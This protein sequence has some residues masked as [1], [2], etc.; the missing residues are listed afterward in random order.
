MKVPLSFKPHS[1]GQKV[2]KLEKVLY[3]LKQSP[4][5]W[6]GRFAKVT[7]AM[8]YK[9]SQRDDMVVKHLALRG[10]MILFE[11]VDDAVVI[12]DYL[13]GRET[14]TKCLVK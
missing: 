3:G 8:G 7:I 13:E 10:V 4:R 12:R 11:Y 6:F 5:A 9:Q 1:K 14:L 2:C